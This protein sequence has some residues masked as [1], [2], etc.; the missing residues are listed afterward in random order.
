M[1]L[2]RHLQS[3][4][5]LG[6]NGRYAGNWAHTISTRVIQL[7]QQDRDELKKNGGKGGG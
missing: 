4:V 2:R 6:F 5:L 3:A 7:I 1:Q